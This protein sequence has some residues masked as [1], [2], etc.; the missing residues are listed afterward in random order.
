MPGCTARY[1][2]VDKL[3]RRSCFFLCCCQVTTVA[4]MKLFVGDG[5]LTMKEYGNSAREQI[6]ETKQ[7]AKLSVP[8]VR[9]FCTLCYIIT[10]LNAHSIHSCDHDDDD[11]YF[12]S[13]NVTEPCKL[14]NKLFYHYK[15]NN[16]RPV[17][18]LLFKK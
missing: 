1:A 6:K 9:P 4:L 10:T 15:E 12:I 7:I 3:I 8:L 13:Y 11:D 18:I 2:G 5:C 14:K 16:P 17:V